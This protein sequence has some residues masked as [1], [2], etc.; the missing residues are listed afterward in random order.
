MTSSKIPFLGQRILGTAPATQ[1]NGS[2]AR[3]FHVQINKT[4]VWLFVEK[5]VS[6]LRAVSRADRLSV[7]GAVEADFPQ[8]HLTSTPH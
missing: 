5:R 6:A 4:P 7:F 1:I 3:K 8:S 2:R